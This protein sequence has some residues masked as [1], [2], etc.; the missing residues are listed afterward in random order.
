MID[1]I[2]LVLSLVVAAAYAC[3][4]DQLSWREHPVQQLVHAI[5]GS[6]TA[7]V[8]TRA[9]L[10]LAEPMHGVVLAG[11]AFMLLLTYRHLPK[12]PPHCVHRRVVELKHEHLRRVAGGSD[13]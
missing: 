6:V 11:M 5:G 9:G 3:R 12:A 13:K 1:S 10:G 8:M 7:W 2:F 4:V